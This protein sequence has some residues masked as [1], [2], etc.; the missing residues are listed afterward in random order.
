M[1]LPVEQILDGLML[2]DGTL[3]PYKA[4]SARLAVRRQVK[5]E[6]Y[7]RWILSVTKEN[8]VWSAP[9]YHHSQTL[10][11]GRVVQGRQHCIRTQRMRG[12]A[13]WRQ[14][15]YPSGVKIV[16]RDL[17]LTPLTMAVWLMDDGALGFSKQR[18]GGKV[19]PKITFHTNGFEREDVEFLCGLLKRDYD[20]KSSISKRG[21]IEIGGRIQVPKIVNAVKPFVEQVS[22]MMYKIDLRRMTPME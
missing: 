3:E 20:V 18:S 4:T 8:L 2:G 21:E 11:D 1:L 12:L 5:H 6:E 10:L 16:P 14:R 17:L 22:C 15:W 7:N 13:V 9:K 19:C